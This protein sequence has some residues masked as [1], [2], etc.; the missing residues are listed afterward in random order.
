MSQSTPLTVAVVG[1]TGVVGRTMVEVLRERPF[2]IGELRLLAS[3]RSAGR[4]VQVGDRSIEIQEATGDAF[5]GVDIA[6]F[7][8]GADISRDLA[9]QAAARGATVI[10][11][12]N[13]WRME[14]DIPLVVSQVNAGDLE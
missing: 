6:L 7:S 9:P 2:P 4:A 12:S 8:A 1:A 5:E 10:D 11:N 3:G 13:A 14:P